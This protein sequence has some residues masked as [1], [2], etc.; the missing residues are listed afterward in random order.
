MSR[1][2]LCNACGEVVGTGWEFNHHMR[3]VHGEREAAHA[4]AD[5]DNTNDDPDD[6][7]D[8]GPNNNDDVIVN[9][10]AFEHSPAIADYLALLERHGTL[11]LE[12]VLKYTG[13][14]ELEREFRLTD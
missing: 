8:D 7:H 5:N 2:T 4:E 9:P 1:M 13:W 6:N 10:A 12:S 14:G 11:D 3:V